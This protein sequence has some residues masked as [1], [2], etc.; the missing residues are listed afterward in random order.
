M[1]LNEHFGC[2]CRTRSQ[3]KL[4]GHTSCLQ[5]SSWELKL[6][7]IK[8][9]NNDLGNLQKTDRELLLHFTICIDTPS[10]DSVGFVSENFKVWNYPFW[11]WSGH[12]IEKQ[13]LTILP[14]IDILHS[15]RRDA[16]DFEKLQSCKF[17]LKHK[18]TFFLQI[19]YTVS[20]IFNENYLI[21]NSCFLIREN[22]YSI[23]SWS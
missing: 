7:Q 19:L 22:I 1:R 12:V 3:L 5:N 10:A 21:H 16:I 17:H 23:Q 4:F 18:E 8:F 9:P 11:P 2:L 6:S 15:D 13:D 20:N 14:R